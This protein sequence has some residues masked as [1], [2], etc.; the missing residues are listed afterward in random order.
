M[1]GGQIK[2]GCSVCDPTFPNLCLALPKAHLLT[3]STLNPGR[4]LARLLMLFESSNGLVRAHKVVKCVF[5]KTMIYPT[6]ALGR[7][8]L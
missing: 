6:R 2:L 7:D 1:G 5:L 8:N 4:A 3:A